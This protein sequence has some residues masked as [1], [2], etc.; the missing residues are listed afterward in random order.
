LY[1]VLLALLA[2]LAFAVDA[3]VAMAQPGPVAQLITVGLQDDISW[4]D[5]VPSGNFADRLVLGPMCDALIDVSPD[6]KLVPKLATAWSL[7]P[8]NKILTLVLRQGVK[9]HDGEAFDAAAVKANIDRAMTLPTS[10]RK[11]EL[12]SI[13]H[14][15]VVNP[16]TVNLVLKAPDSS[17]LASLAYQAGMM[18]APKTFAQ[19]NTHPVCAGPYQFVRR[20]QNDRIEMEKFPGYWE[21]DKYPI[22]KI[23]FVPIPDSTVRLANVRSGSLDLL[24]RLSP[25]DLASV[26]ID[27]NLKL[28]VVDGLGFFDIMFNISVGPRAVK[29]FQD[30]RVRQA[31]DL[32]IDRDAINQLVGSGI[33][34][35]AS[36]AISPSSP[37]HDARLETTRRDIP[38]ARALLKAA[39]Y[40]NLNLEL[41]FGNSTSANQVAQMLQAMMGEAG[42]S[43]RLTPSDYATALSSAR[44]SNF[45]MLYAIWSGRPDPDANLTAYVSCKGVLNHSGYCNPKVDQ[46]LQAAR[47]KQTFAERKPLYDQV[48]TIIAEDNP[49]LFIYVPPFPFVMSRK[50]QGFVAYP[51]G[52]IRFRGMSIGK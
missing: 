10:V 52:V 8:D 22:Q 49:L 38:K 3:S 27:P 35:P 21:A 16:Y 7:S 24:E 34:T 36:Q 26:K 46:L 33:M 39:G 29:A 11:T 18:L 50:V 14:V 32:T 37:Y 43:L 4:L 2:L 1:Q 47:E 44:N 13:D 6:Q 23:T 42:I 5:P 12:A 19:A 31:I 40:P 30:K 45:E 51:D 48:Q 25:S 20:I 17:L 15:E 9:F 41:T 28:A